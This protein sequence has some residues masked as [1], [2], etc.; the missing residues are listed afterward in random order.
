MPAN[1][2]PSAGA[3]AA[4]AVVGTSS[5]VMPARTATNAGPFPPTPPTSGVPL[6]GVILNPSGGRYKASLYLLVS[7]HSKVQT[8][9][10]TLVFKV[11]H[12][13][14][15]QSCSSSKA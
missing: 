7:F 4:G 14:P 5:T 15:L 3:Q 13:C 12:T 10:V 2:G 8:S 11:Q 9:F 6:T 1:R